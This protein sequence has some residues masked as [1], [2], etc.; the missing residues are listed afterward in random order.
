MDFA[1]LGYLLL[2]AFLGATLV[3][4]VI[5]LFMDNKKHNKNYNK[6]GAHNKNSFLSRLKFFSEHNKN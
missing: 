3:I 4:V 2:G 5:V 1:D 6:N